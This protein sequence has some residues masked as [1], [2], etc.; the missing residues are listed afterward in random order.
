MFGNILIWFVIIPVLMMA[1]LGVCRNSSMAAI[2]AVMVIGS[3]IL[4]ALAIWLCVDFLAL[5]GAGVDDEMLFTGSWMWYA[6]LNIHLAVGVDG[7]S[8]LML[9]LSAVI[10]FAGTFA[11]WKINPLP[12]NFF[13]W[14]ALLSTGVFGFF[15]SIDMFT[16]FMFYEVALI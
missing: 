16:M 11:S 2:R 1:G 3:T 15:I 10:V 7:I 5:R 13:L 8:V 6:P 9:L 12:K 14:F 4:L